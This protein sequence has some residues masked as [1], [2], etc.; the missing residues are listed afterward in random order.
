VVAGLG[1]LLAVAGLLA[2]AAW[3]VA[4]GDPRTVVLVLTGVTVVVIAV[5][6][7]R[8]GTL[9][10][11]A[12][13][14]NNAIGAGRF[15]GIGNVPYG[16]LAGAA[17]VA[18]GLALE[19]Y[20]RRALPG[21]AAGLAFVVVA[22]GAPMFGADVGGLLAAVP[23]VTLLLAGWRGRL[24]R[25]AAVIA[26][27]LGCA[28]IAG[29]V[30]FERFRPAEHQTHLGRALAGGSMLETAIR[31]GLSSLDT[32]RTSPWVIVV[33]IAAAGLFAVRRRLALG[34]ASRA[35]AGAVAVVAV[36]GTVL[37]DS[38]VAVAGAVVFVA[39]AAALALAQPGAGAGPGGRPA[40]AATPVASARL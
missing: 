19:R 2:A 27:G 10:L 33:V 15:A 11:D 26:G 28:A 34:P 32:F 40:A 37:N 1:V 39:W 17:L 12:P 31:R 16:F 8:N 35:A 6:A 7:V 29:L 4:R 25:R 21:V 38:G 13:M 18:A 24:S 22:D 14:A 3:R 5:D 20:G 36:L 9:E 30:A 23:A